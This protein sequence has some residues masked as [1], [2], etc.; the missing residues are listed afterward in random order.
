MGQGVKLQLQVPI[1]LITSKRWEDKKAAKQSELQYLRLWQ[2]GRHQCLI[3]LANLSSS[4]YKEYKSKL[5]DHVA[6]QRSS[7]G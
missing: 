7:Q 6:R 1:K 5:D 4:K 3:V 2:A